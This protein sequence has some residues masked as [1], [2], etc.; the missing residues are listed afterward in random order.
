MDLPLEPSKAAILPE[1]VDK[2][3]SVYGS[4]FQTNYHTL[5]LHGI[6]RR[7]N[8][9]R[10]QFSTTRVVLHG[11]TGVLA[12]IRFHQIGDIT[13]AAHINAYKKWIH[14][15]HLPAWRFQASRL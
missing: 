14:N 5:K 10:Q 15:F 9:F 4:G 11:K 13:P 12:A 3:V 8:S 6:K 7:H 1:R 2:A